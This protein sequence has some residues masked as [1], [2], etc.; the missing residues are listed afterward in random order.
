[1]ARIVAFL[2]LIVA[3]ATISAAPNCGE[4]EVFNSCGTS[5]PSTC[6]NPTPSICTL[7]CIPGCDCAEG[8]VRDAQNRCILLQ[9]C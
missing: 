2:L 7:A 4:N 6:Q 3:V 1:M 8:Y 5:C 9:Y